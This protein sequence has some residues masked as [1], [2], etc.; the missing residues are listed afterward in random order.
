MNSLYTDKRNYFNLKLNLLN[1]HNKELRKQR[2]QEVE[3]EIP[4]IIFDYTGFDDFV[5][6]F[7]NKKQNKKIIKHKKNKWNNDSNLRT[8]FLQINDWK[9]HYNAEPTTTTTVSKKSNKKVA[10][11][12]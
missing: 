4:K 2:I 6:T 1:S 3:N 10:F 9:M 7:K 5:V 8:A 12:N 11:T